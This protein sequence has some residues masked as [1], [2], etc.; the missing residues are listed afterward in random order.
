MNNKKKNY[1]A[2][3]LDWFRFS[4][5]GSSRNGLPQPYSPETMKALD[6]LFAMIRQISPYYEN[7]VRK[8]FFQVDRGSIEDYGNY[9]ELLA[10]GTVKNREEFEEMWKL[11]YPDETQWFAFCFYEDD[12]NGYRGIWLDSNLIMETMPDVPAP[13]YPVDFSEFVWWIVKKVR[14]CLPDIRSGEYNRKIRR[15]L[16][17]EFRIG[18]IL[19]N[20]FWEVYPE[21]KAEYFSELSDADQKEFLELMENYKKDAIPENLIVDMTSGLFYRCCAMGYAANHYE[22]SDTLSPKELYYKHADGRD[23]G[24]A[25]VDENSPNEFDYWYTH[26]AQSGHPWEVCRGGNSTHVS[27]YI[28]KIDAGFYFAAAGS[29]W[30]RS[31]ETIKFYLALHR[32][33][34]PVVIDDGNLLADR[35]RG[36]DKIGIVPKGVTPCYCSGYFPQEVILD[37]MNLR[38]EKREEFA[39]RCV[40]R[41]EPELTIIQD[42]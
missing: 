39:A 25:S 33:G 30:G 26:R 24:L 19:R 9:D 37:F 13:P 16:P 15:S 29:S 6:D 32:A 35:I 40:W 28:C 31:I 20:A 1:C 23:E 7:G 8:L 42:Q 11:D 14:E 10:D 2:P 18:T 3:V 4:H 38:H 17:P 22:G 12:K 36:V 5:T 41:D 27:L 21:E 34:M